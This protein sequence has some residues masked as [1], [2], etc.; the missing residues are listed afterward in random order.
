MPP[1][2]LQPALGALRGV[3]A[4]MFALAAMVLA[5]AAHVAG[6]GAL[7]SAPALALVAVP[8]AWGAVALTG[9]PR[10]RL[11]L[12]VALGVAQL[13]LHEAFM[14]LAGPSCVGPTAASMTG[15]PGSH[16]MTGV[17]L[18]CGV[19]GMAHTAQMT[20]VAGMA[21]APAVLM[22]VGHAAATVATAAL[23]A[24]GDRLLAALPGL[25]LG[26]LTRWA[27][28]ALVPALPRPVRRPR[29]GSVR[30]PDELVGG[31]VRRRGPPGAA[32]IPVP[33]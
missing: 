29:P 17:W 30:T 24:Y 28:A 21:A 10:G 18:T 27:A 15:M 19:P 1:A 13:A 32:R 12:L 22:L 25:L 11:A 31:T 5:A 16:G 23:L 33:A 4:A 14:A 7:P 3:R 8:L 2:R 26:H 6:G 20:G 9:R